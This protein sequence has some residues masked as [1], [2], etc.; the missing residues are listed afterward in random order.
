MSEKDTVNGKIEGDMLKATQRRVIGS[1]EGL[2]DKCTLEPMFGL[3]ADSTLDNK[4]SLTDGYDLF[5]KY[6]HVYAGTGNWLKVSNRITSYSYNYA[7]DNNG[8]ESSKSICKLLENQRKIG[9][10]VKGGGRQ[11]H[12][13]ERYLFNVKKNCNKTLIGEKCKEQNNSQIADERK[14]IRTGETTNKF[15]CAAHGKYLPSHKFNRLKQNGEHKPAVKHINIDQPQKASQQQDSNYVLLPETLPNKVIAESENG[16]WLGCKI[17]HS[18]N[19]NKKAISKWGAIDDHR[20]DMKVTTI[21]QKDQCLS[22][23]SDAEICENTLQVKGI[24]SLGISDN[25]AME[26]D[27]GKT[28]GSPRCKMVKSTRK[29]MNLFS[30]LSQEA[31]AAM[32]EAIDEMKDHDVD[33]KQNKSRVEKYNHQTKDTV[34]T[35]SLE[36]VHRPKYSSV[37]RSVPRPCSFVDLDQI[38]SKQHIPRSISVPNFASSFSEYSSSCKSGVARVKQYGSLRNGLLP[39][40][41]H[42]REGTFVI[43]PMGYDSRFS[44]RPVKLDVTDETP[45]EVKE[46]AFMK[47]RDWLIKHT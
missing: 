18:Q 8:Y 20:K 2:G 25:S 7:L 26:E 40:G 12:A 36:V 32:Q 19:D 17:D 14:A 4:E 39:S 37:S 44:D 42:K 27:T 45:E 9:T 21:N 1:G 29:H 34:P 38:A 5:A 6:R 15:L 3:N 28:D 11:K 13:K 41:A 33:R 24:S 16:N 47:C 43:T 46:Q 31:Q 23:S 10:N 30:R 35:E 22:S